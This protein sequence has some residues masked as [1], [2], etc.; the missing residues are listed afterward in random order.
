M[1]LILN[2]F[3]ICSMSFN[4]SDDM[5]MRK[6]ISSQAMIGTVLNK[7][8]IGGIRTGLLGYERPAFSNTMY[9]SM[10]NVIESPVFILHEYAPF[11]AM[12]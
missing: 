3:A 10:N 2:L 8:K 12:Q 9:I 6:D 4:S 7:T 1:T 11:T 5:Y